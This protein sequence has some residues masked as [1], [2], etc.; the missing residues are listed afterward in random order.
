V[1]RQARPE[2]VPG[3]AEA[4]GAAFEEDPI[5]SWFWNKPSGRREYI[6]G[7]Y[8]LVA[9]EHYLEHGQVFVAEEDGEIAGCSMWSPPGS[10]R[11]PPRVE[12][13]TTRYVVP[14]LGFRVPMASIAMRRIERKHPTSPHWYLS[15][16]GVRPQSQGR[17]F[18]SRL[19]FEMLARCDRERTPAYLES[20]TERSRA[21]YERHGFRTTEVIRMPRG[22]PPLWLMW[23]GHHHTSCSSIT[24]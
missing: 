2:D 23:R 19:M 24:P 11:F 8:E 20:S 14:R 16:L 5:A 12:V 22:G 13:R 3:I 9:R 15:E 4:M 18:G 10:W 7:W 21:L 17:G 1:I 6:T